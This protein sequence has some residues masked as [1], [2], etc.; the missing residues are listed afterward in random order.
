MFSFYTIRNVSL[1]NEYFISTQFNKAITF[2]DNENYQ[3]IKA[4]HKIDLLYSCNSMFLGV[5]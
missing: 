2:F 4:I 1:Y 5:N 3:K